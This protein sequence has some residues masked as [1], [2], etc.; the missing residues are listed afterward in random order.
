MQAEPKGFCVRPE[1]ISFH[2]KPRQPLGDASFVRGPVRKG[3]EN[4]ERAN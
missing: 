1:S 4:R 2:L 3:A